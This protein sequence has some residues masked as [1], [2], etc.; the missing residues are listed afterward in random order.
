MLAEHKWGHVGTKGYAQELPPTVHAEERGKVVGN[1][2]GGAGGRGDRG[3]GAG[4]L[5]CL[6]SAESKCWKVRK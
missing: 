2:G 1:N 3:V 6:E 5:G 4:V